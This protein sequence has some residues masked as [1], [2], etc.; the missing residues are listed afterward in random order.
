MCDF[1]SLYDKTDPFSRKVI[2]HE[3]KNGSIGSSK[4]NGSIENKE[5]SQ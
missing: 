2:V 1:I 3:N 4:S 5:D